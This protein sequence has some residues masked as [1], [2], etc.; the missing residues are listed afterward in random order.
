MALTFPNSQLNSIEPMDLDNAHTL[1]AFMYTDKDFVEIDKQVLLTNSW[2]FIG[3]SSQLK[4]AGDRI[5][6][7]ICGKPVLVVRTKQDEI[8]AFHNVCR[9]RAGPVATENGNSPLLSCK[10]HGWTYTLDG[11]LMSAPEMQSTPNFELC[12]FHLPRVD[13]AIWQGLIFVN[14]GKEQSADVCLETM[15]QGIAERILPIDLSVLEYSHR[16]EYIVQCNWK[17]YMDNYLEGYHLPIVHPGLNKLL[18]YRSYEISLHPW[19]SYQF[20]PLEKVESQNNFYGEGKAHY[21]CVFPNLMLNILPGRL[22]TNIV[23][24]IDENS[25]KIIFDYYYADLDSELTKNLIR[26]D[27]DFSDEIQSEDINICEAVQKGLMS[28]TYESGRFCIK[29]ENAVLHYQELIRKT[30][31]KSID[32]KQIILT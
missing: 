5:V 15:L 1:P 3:H 9:H 13:L 21:F 14:L 26:Q 30:L 11:E 12:Q 31:K 29:R 17:V 6:A 22:Q 25:C 18:D 20:S 10:Y 28:G 19:Y 27:Q 32:L 16:Q 7:E 24:P 8:K 2:Q 4:R 23:E